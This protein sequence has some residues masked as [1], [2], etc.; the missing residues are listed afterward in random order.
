MSDARPIGVFD[1]GVGGVS[2]LRDLVRLLPRER[3]IYYGDNKN[4]PYGTR[5]EEEIRALSLDVANWLL[6]RDV[7]AMLVA[8]NTATSAAIQTLRERL[9]IPVVGM[10]PALKPAYELHAD[11]KILVLATPATLRQA[12]FHRLYERYGEHAVALPCPELVE[13]VE[14]GRCEGDEIDAYLARRFAD[15]QGEKLAAAVLG[16]T[17]FSFLKKAL[18]RALPGVPLLDGN[19]G[20]ARRLEYLLRENGTLREDGEGSVEFFTSGDEDVFLPLMRRLFAA[21]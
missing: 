1:S 20:S 10:E 4:A 9:S 6:S 7:K 19:E 15:V 18:G 8:C 2:V 11:G 21:R 5:S 17:H 3:F 13:F 16:C 12:K 14:S